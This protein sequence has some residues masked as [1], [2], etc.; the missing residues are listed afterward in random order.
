M[1]SD[2]GLDLVREFHD[3]FDV[4]MPSRPTIPDEPVHT[5][6]L[7]FQQ[8]AAELAESLRVAAGEAGGSILLLR[9]H[10]IQEELAELAL[11]FVNRDLVECLDAL[12]DL[13]YVLDGAWLVTGMGHLK[14]AALREVHRSNMSKLDTNG[15]PMRGAGGRVLKS[16]QYSPPDL[17]ALLHDERGR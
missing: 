2:L 11:S 8:R 10:L 9:L 12:T 14:E 15:R 13:S 4:D 5:S 17:A 3:A 6:L 1:S 16:D 7:I